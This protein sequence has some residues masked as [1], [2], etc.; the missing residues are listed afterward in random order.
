MIMASLPRLVLAALVAASAVHAVPQAQMA[1]AAAAAAPSSASSSASSTGT[2]TGTGGR[3]C[4]NS[5]TLCGRRYNAV[6]HMGAHNSAFLRDQSTGDSLSGNQFLKATLALDAGL[7]L[8]QAQVHRPNASSGLELCHTSCGLLDAGPLEAWLSEIGAWMGRNP[9]EVV[10]VLL[11]NEDRAPASEFGS[12]FD[13]A[14]L[15]GMAYR[16]ASGS[17]ALSAEW[18][19]LQDMVD[20]NARVVAFVTGIQY[21]PGTPY[22]LPELS[23]VFETAYEVTSLDGFNCTVDRPSRA[24][25]APSA[26]SSGFL[27]LVNHFKYQAVVAGILV[28]DVSTIDAV[29]SA[30]VGTGSGSG[31]GSLG[32]HLARCRAEWNRAPNFVL[33]DFWNRGQVIAALD[34]MN[35]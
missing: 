6:T 7:R 34:A 3:A 15:S 21:S 5:P 17:N 11:V 32:G 27:S 24:G 12:V 35:G 26:L 10:T 18:P 23:H 1:S 25:P 29:N 19:T 30:A 28:P 2:G 13:R 20:A 33:V 4:N 14:G 8:L 22:L 9:S 16:P 31:S